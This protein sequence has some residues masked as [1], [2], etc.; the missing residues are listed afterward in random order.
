MSIGWW[1]GGLL[2]GSA[3]LYLIVN[4]FNR[5]VKNP[6]VYDDL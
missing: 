1:V 2:L 5:V 6:E 3:V 4:P